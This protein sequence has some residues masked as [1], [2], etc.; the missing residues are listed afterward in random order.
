MPRESVIEKESIDY[1]SYRGWIY[2][3]LKWIGRRGAPDRLFVRRGR[4][5]FVEFKQAGEGPTTQQAREHQRL[6][7][8]GATVHVVD[9]VDRARE[10]FR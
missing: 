6:R 4:C 2:R 9:S 7:D 8:A 5:L 10:I 1:A 3:K